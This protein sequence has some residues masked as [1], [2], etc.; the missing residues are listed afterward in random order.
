M[1]IRTPKKIDARIDRRARTFVS[2][3]DKTGWKF[4]GSQNPHKAAAESHGKRKKGLR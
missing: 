1:K 4:P 3:K 2:R